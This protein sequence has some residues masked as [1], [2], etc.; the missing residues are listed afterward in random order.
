MCAK[1]KMVKTRVA[2]AVARPDAAVDRVRETRQGVVDARAARRDD[3]YDAH[4]QSSKTEKQ[5]MASLGS[6]RAAVPFLR[7]QKRKLGLEEEEEEEET[8]KNRN[9]CGPRR[10]RRRTRDFSDAT[11]RGGTVS[12]A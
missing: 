8:E 11:R 10:R 6:D 12:A 1:N 9:A 5:K 4:S 3:A 2:N 7:G